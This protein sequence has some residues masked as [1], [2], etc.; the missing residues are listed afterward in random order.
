M[1]TSDEVQIEFRPDMEL[2]CPRCGH[3]V[4]V[5]TWGEGLPKLLDGTEPR[6]S[7]GCTDGVPLTVIEGVP[8]YV[9]AHF[10]IAVEGAH[11]T[12]IDPAFLQSLSDAA[13][14]RM[15]MTPLKD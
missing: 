5:A 15:I 10:L 6:V 1:A 3:M 9:V 8:G 4:D 13:G 2:T 12:T 7:C 14:H 11:A